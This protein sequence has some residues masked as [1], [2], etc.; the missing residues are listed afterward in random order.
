MKSGK[1]RRLVTARARRRATRPAS[2]MR[3]VTAHA[4]SLQLAVWR[5]GGSGVTRRAGSCLLAAVGLVAAHTCGVFWNGTRVLPFVTTLAG[6]GE[7]SAM[8]LVTVAAGHMPWVGASS[9]GSVARSAVRQFLARVVRQTG[10]TSL[11]VLMTAACSDALH[12]G[13]VA[14]TARR[15]FQRGEHEIM[16]LVAL[17]ANRAFVERAIRRNLGVALAAR[18]G[19]RLGVSRVRVRIVTARASG[20][21]T[22]R[23][24]RVNRLVAV[25]ARR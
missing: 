7:R 8:R 11:A 14:R 5:I 3:S 22:A 4:A 23:M 18:N 1:S 21:A 17:G 12:L 25:G 10:V 20:A 24:L 6:F 2:A 13:P 16:R 19:F 9:L 15:L